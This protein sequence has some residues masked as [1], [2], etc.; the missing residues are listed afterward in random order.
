M[1]KPQNF[2]KKKLR[3]SRRRADDQGFQDIPFLMI[4]AEVEEATVALALEA[5]VDGYI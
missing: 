1:I 4:T 3:L 5:G 2:H